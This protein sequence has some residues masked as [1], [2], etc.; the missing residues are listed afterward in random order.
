MKCGN[1]FPPGPGGR[2][3]I[4]VV[5]DYLPGPRLQATGFAGVDHRLHVRTLVGG[6]KREVHTVIRLRKGG[7]RGP[8]HVL[9]SGP[10]SM[11][12]RIFF[13]E[14]GGMYSDHQVAPASASE[15]I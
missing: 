7:G 13:S 15:A 8:G 10:S 12:R 5:A 11:Q 3:G 14:S 9:R 4:S 1:A 2:L 6:E